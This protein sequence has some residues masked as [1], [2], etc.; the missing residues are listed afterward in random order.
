MSNETAYILEQREWL[1]DIDTGDVVSVVVDRLAYRT[2]V[3]ATTAG[4]EWI[5]ESDDLDF[6]IIIAEYA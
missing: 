3:E 2:L 1:Q 6:E 5:A 4:H